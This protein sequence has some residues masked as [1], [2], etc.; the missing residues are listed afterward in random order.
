MALLFVYAVFFLE[1]LG[2]QLA[3]GVVVL[4]AGWE[5]ARLSGVVSQRSRLAFAGMVGT[6]CY[7]VAL[8]SMPFVVLWITPVLWLAALMWVVAYPKPKGWQARPVRLLFG[9]L[10]LVTTWSA[11]VFM[12]ESEQFVTWIL[13]LM[14]LIW[15]ADSGAYF[16]GK[17]FGKRKL[18]PSV[19]PG[20]SWEGVYGGLLLT[21]L[22]V[23]GF[24]VYQGF[25]LQQ[26][27]TLALIAFVTVLTSVLGDLTESLFKR[28]EALKDSS[29]L[30]PGHGG[31]MDRVDSLTSA[32]P[33][34]VLLLALVGWM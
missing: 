20:K 31:V 19:S 29:Q 12:R 4:L 28:H 14:A 25:G 8:F 22:I 16:S 24:C 26:W 18:A 3:I 6:L 33:L 7:G 17:A 1:S 13:L 10:V 32:A 34:Y 30:I 15:G 23:V 21:Q 27:I 2:F 11:M 5:W 9:L